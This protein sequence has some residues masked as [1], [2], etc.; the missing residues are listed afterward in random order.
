MNFK[1]IP[2]KNPKPDSKRFI[3]ILTGRCKGKTPLI[4]YIID[5]TV[6]KPVQEN[7]LNLKWSNFGTDRN[8]DK[9]YLNNFIQVWYK[10]GYDIVRFEQGFNFSRNLLL[11]E[12]KSFGA[13][14]KRAWADE[15]NG[16]IK[17][18]NDLES[19]K[20][21]KIEDFDFSDLEYINNNL[22]EGMGFITCHAGGIFEHLSAVMS[23]EGLSYAL[24]EEP[25][26]V[27]TLADR[28]GELLLSFYKQILSLNNLSAILQ[29]D[30]MGFRTSTLIS[31]DALRR[32]CLPWHKKFAEVTHK[33]GRPYFLH[34]CGNIESIMPDLINDI[35]IDGKH[36]Y[37]DLIIPI[38]YFQEKYGDKIAVLG[39][40]DVNIL[41]MGST[42]KIRSRTRNLIEKCGNTGRFAIGAGN[43]IASYIPYLNY[44]SMVDE[45]NN[46][47]QNE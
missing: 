39:G 34:S 1:N 7:L 16:T 12:D 2:L 5:D 46:I 35:K 3:D 43:S 26:L 25:E 24:F 41:A 32:Y 15:H 20:F 11:A 14:K 38:E 30:D 8:T 45:V 23:L 17:N 44:L 36:S 6:L 10:L 13:D 42:D 31:P 22:P 27:K 9:N 21:P 28:I 37:E 47:K 29:G 18:W 19:F 40:L 33:S 4:E